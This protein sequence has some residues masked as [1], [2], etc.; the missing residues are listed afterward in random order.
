MNDSDLINNIINISTKIISGI[1][2]YKNLSIINIK[3]IYI[4]DN[5]MNL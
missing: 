4:I 3:L 2:N 1:E 5:Y